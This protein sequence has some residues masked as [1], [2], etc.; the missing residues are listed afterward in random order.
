VGPPDLVTEREHV[1]CAMR[2]D[3]GPRVHC[4]CGGSSNFSCSQT[5]SQCKLSPSSTSSDVARSTASEDAASSLPATTG[6]TC[7]SV[8]A[9]GR[10][11]RSAP[12]EG[13]DHHLADRP[14]PSHHRQRN[15][16]RQV[17]PG[18]PSSSPRAAVGPALEGTSRLPPKCTASAEMA[19]PSPHRRTPPARTRGQTLRCAPRPAPQQETHLASARSRR[20]Q[21]RQRHRPA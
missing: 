12:N 1:E 19:I 2:S 17:S 18:R 11:G 6:S 20:T 7:C 15:E 14:S 10:R 13:G 4:N 16:R 5:S 3:S 21:A 8:M 9:G